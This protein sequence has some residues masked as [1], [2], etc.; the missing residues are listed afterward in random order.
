MSKPEDNDRSSDKE[1]HRKYRQRL[2]R[3][4]VVIATLASLTCAH[5]SWTW[6]SGFHQYRNPEPVC[7][8]PL[9]NL[10]AH[11]P[12]P[13][14]SLP[15]RRAHDSLDAFFTKRASH[16]DIDSI[17]VAIVTP[18]GNIFEK[19]YGILH[20]N[21][22]ESSQPVNRDSIYRIASITKMFTV[23]ETLVLR[24]RGILNW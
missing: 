10:L 16:P 3:A 17:S 11:Y 9:P 18:F 14:D 19:G 20:A 15:L 1:A 4:A 13:A 6:V 8:A 5:I 7:K 22:S 12:V 2:T 23:L 24:E 21:G